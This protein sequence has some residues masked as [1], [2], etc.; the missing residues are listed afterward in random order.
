MD[1]PDQCKPNFDLNSIIP[2]LKSQRS[3]GGGLVLLMLI[4]LTPIERT[5]QRLS[6]PFLSILEASQAASSSL[7]GVKLK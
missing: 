2:C 1:K 3:P 7:G 4:N 6:L 5:S